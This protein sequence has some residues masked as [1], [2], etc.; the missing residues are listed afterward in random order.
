MKDFRSHL[1]SFT[2]GEV[3]EEFFGQLTDVKFQTGLALCRNMI[4]KPHGPVSNRAGTYFVKAAKY[5]DK[6]AHILPFTFSTDQTM[7]LE[8]GEGYIRFHTNG[9]TLSA[10]TPTA[11]NS[12]TAYTVGNL[13]SSA[14][15][16]YYCILGHTNQ[17]PPNA[18]YWYAM[19]TDGTYEIPSPYLEADLFALNFEQDQDVI[20]ITR[21][22]YD[23]RELR[24]YGATD[25][26]LVTST[27]ASELSAPGSPTATPTGG[28]AHSYSY[29]ITAIGDDGIQESPVSATA[30]CT[31][32]TPLGATHFNTITYTTVSG[33]LRYNIY[34]QQ[35]GLFGYI[36]QTDALTFRDDNIE[37]DLSKTP[38]IVNTPFSGT[39]NKPGAVTYFE[40]RKWFAGST[41]KQLNFWATRPGSENDLS[42]SL[43][44]RADDA[45]QQRIRA[46]EASIIRHL[47]PLGSLIV[48]TASGE[49]RITSINTDA[50][51]PDSISIRPQSYIGASTARPAVV[52]SSVIYGAARGGAL[53]ELGYSSD[54]EAYT[55]SNLSIRAPHLFDDYQVRSLTFSRSPEPVV[56]AT[57]TSKKLIGLTYMPDQEVRG[58]H[59][60]DT[61]TL[62]GQSD[63][64]SA[65]AIAEGEYDVVYMVVKRVI[66]GAT[67]R[68]VE[69]MP[70]RKFAT[71][72]DAY[73]VDCGLTYDGT[74]IS[75]IT[76]GLEHL[77][78]ETVSILADGAVLPQQTVTGGGLPDAFDAPA[79]K[80]HV[81]LPITAD[82]Q[83]R[84]MIVELRGVGAYGQGSVKNINRVFLRVYESSGIFAG[85]S[86][87]QLA[88]FE[89]RTT[90]PYGTPPNLVSDEIEVRVPGLWQ[91]D[92]ALCVRQTDPLPLTIASMT[93]E[94]SIGS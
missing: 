46:R 41:N 56:W 76:S 24:R 84:P 29:K 23:P 62:A 83:T 30:T 73:F 19:P 16:N 86:F 88:P 36:G 59:W 70:A 77:E 47:V 75:T 85:P 37:A 81:G 51:S 69:R 7:A 63:I 26:R 34:K 94:A 66:D 91:P 72:A 22:G 8:F 45:I 68:Y 5:A 17:A 74:P 27:F 39:G 54:A 31:N 48:L 14:G 32:A 87:D 12:G 42:Y 49:F 80:I 52:N 38:P 15:V 10:G 43:P 3:T 1:R 53:R 2:G 67:V 58:L 28:G 57:S 60:H 25:W 40:Q 13:A 92:G 79:S 55:T 21:I 90:E 20:T 82:I 4:V 64:E 9:G 35:N 61:Y 50:I 18:T 93:I 71:L 11:W 33:A 78:G 44:F 65:C 6:M 89:Q